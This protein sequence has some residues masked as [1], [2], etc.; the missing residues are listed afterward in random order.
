MCLSGYE[1]HVNAAI[2]LPVVQSRW[3]NYSSS[4]GRLLYY[5]IDGTPAPSVLMTP[6]S[7]SYGKL[8]CHYILGKPATP[9][10]I[11]C[12]CLVFMIDLLL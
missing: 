11:V 12:C 1:R 9:V 7:N 4:Y 2:M 6:Y 3:T 8:L 10:I 5:C